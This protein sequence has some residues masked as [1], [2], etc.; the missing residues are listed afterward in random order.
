MCRSRR[1]NSWRSFPRDKVTLSIYLTS[2]APATD[3][4]NGIGS[5]AL[6][7]RSFNEASENGPW[8][9]NRSPTD[10]VVN[11]TG[12]TNALDPSV[13]DLGFSA[14]NNVDSAGIGSPDVNDTDLDRTGLAGTQSA[15]GGWDPTY[16]KVPV[17]LVGTADFTV[18]N[19]S[20]AGANG[21]FLWQ[22]DLNAFFSTPTGPGGGA[23]VKSL[24]GSGT[25]TN[26]ISATNLITGAGQIG[27][28]V[29]L[30]VIPEPASI[31][32]L[33]LGGLGLLRRRRSA[34]SA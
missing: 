31:G 19:N 33:A 5:I 8:S 22:V 4:V 24:T 2:S 13:L 7:I 1:V 17:L 27:A 34:C 10:T 28:P 30:Q 23:I 14:G 9:T 18:A 29:T 11:A 26:G 21:G 25:T 20:P 3:I 15:T 12:G 32:L 16:G 6:G